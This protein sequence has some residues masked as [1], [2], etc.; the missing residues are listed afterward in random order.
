ME[1]L[2]RLAPP[3]HRRLEARA[4]AEHVTRDAEHLD[5]A[6]RAASEARERHLRRLAEQERR[7]WLEQTK[8]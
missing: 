8:E 6:A 3:A 1:Q 5:G 7:W 2:E 4:F